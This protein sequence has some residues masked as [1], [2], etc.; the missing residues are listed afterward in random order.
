[1]NALQLSCRGC[2]FSSG[3]LFLLYELCHDLRIMIDPDDKVAIPFSMKLRLKLCHQLLQLLRLLELAQL[4]LRCK[5]QRSASLRF[6]AS[7]ISELSLRGSSL[8]LMQNL[9]PLQVRK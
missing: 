8:L 1:M 9:L 2:S 7:C 3:S 6:A 4:P 5:T